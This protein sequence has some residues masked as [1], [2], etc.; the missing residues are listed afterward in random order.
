M[1]VA[2]VATQLGKQRKA[3]GAG[4]HDVKQNQ[5]GHTLGQ[6]LAKRSRAGETLRLQTRLLERIQGELADVDLV[7]NVVNHVTYP[8]DS[9]TLPA[10]IPLRS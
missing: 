10:I 6:S 5:V 7:L 3:V 4:Q 2:R 1:R 8:L 9:P